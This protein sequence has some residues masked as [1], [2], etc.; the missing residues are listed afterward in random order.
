MTA[1]D[2]RPAIA[3]RR[4]NP[5][6]GK[7]TRKD[8]VERFAL[9][10]EGDGLPRIA[11]RIFGLLLTGERDLS[12]DEITHELGASKA[13]ASVN[14]RLLE[15]RGF[16]ERISRPGDRRDYY[17]IMPDLFERTMEQRL[18]KWHRL[19]DVVMFGLSAA[20]LSPQVRNRLKDFEAAQNNIREVIETALARLRTRRRR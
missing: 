15:Q 14:T 13:S 16:I 3:A 9:A 6:K 11:G 19:H 7:A 5:T 17:R 8:F 18:A 10:Q 2:A 4:A 1:T 12:L 20:D